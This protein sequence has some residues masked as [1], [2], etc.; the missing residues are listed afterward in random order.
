MR[1]DSHDL[2]PGRK[3]N[4]RKKKKQGKEKKQMNKMNKR[5]RQE[6]KQDRRKK[7]RKKERKKNIL[8]L[9]RV[10]GSNRRSCQSKLET[11][12]ATD[13]VSTTDMLLRFVFNC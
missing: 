8:T 4:K 11:T 7:E 10:I 5:R 12:A 1:V 3:K 9:T 6:R 13:V 2:K